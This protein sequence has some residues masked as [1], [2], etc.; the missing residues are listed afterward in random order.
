MSPNP[1]DKISVRSLCLHNLKSID[2][3]IPHG[4]F[5]VITGPSGAGK[6]SLALDSIYAE[7]QRRY[8]ETFSPYARQFLERLPRPPAKRI[9]GLPAAV[10]IGQSNPVKNSRST[11]GTLAEI[12]YPAHMLFYYLAELFCPECDIPVKKYDLKEAIDELK[13][14]RD[15]DGESRALIVASVS[16][17]RVEDFI[18]Q[19][20]FRHYQEGE[21]KELE[22]ETWGNKAASDE[23]IEIVID[24]ITLKSLDTERIRDSV[25]Q[26]FIAGGGKFSI[27]SWE[28]G[29]VVN[30]YNGLVCRGCGKTFSEPS[31][32]LFSFNSPSGACPACQGFGRQE[33][34][35]WDLVVPDH[36][37]S[38][39][40]GA[41]RP[42]ENWTGKKKRLLTWCVK[43][44]IP[45]ESPW[46]ELSQDVKDIIL[47]GGRGWPGIKSFFDR[48]EKK[49]YK[50]HIRILLA[51]YRKFVT[52]NQCKGKRFRKEVNQYR[53]NGLTLPDFYAL[54][55]EHALD[56]T[57]EIEKKT[58]KN[59][60]CQ[61]LA[62]DLLTRFETLCRAGLGYLSSERQAR[63]LS[64]GEVARISLARG[65]GSNLARTLYVLDEPTAGL[66]PAD[67]DRITSLIKG[68]GKRSNTVIAVEHNRQMAKEADIEIALGPGSGKNGG[69]V[70]YTGDPLFSPFNISDRSLKSIRPRIE[71]RFI[72]IKGASVHNL[73][74]ID[75]RLPLGAVSCITGV[76]GSGKSSLAD[77]IIYR[78]A[79]RIK[80]VAT[81]RPGTFRSIEN[82]QEIK[83]IILSDQTSLSRN[84]RACPG[85]FLKIMDVVRK[86]FANTQEAK[87]MGLV[88]GNFSFNTK[89][90]R[91]PLCAGQGYEKIDMQF[92]P[93]MTLP[94]PECRGSRFSNH[95]MGILYNGINIAQI[96]GMT[97]DEILQLPDMTPSA[98]KRL[99]LANRLGLGHLEL[100]R[101]LDTLSSGEAR[102]LKIAVHLLSGDLKDSLIVMDEPSKGLF[103]EEKEQLFSVLREASSKLNA[104][105]VMVEHDPDFVTTSDWVIDLGPG[106][107]D[108]GGQ[109]LYQGAPPGLMEC[110]TSLTGKFLAEK[111]TS[112]SHDTF[113]EKESKAEQTELKP[114]ADAIHIRGARHHNLKNIDIDIPHG[115]F[116]VITGVSGSGKS[117]IAFDIIFAEGQRR[118]IEG[119]SS[120]MKQYIKLYEQP[121]LDLAEGLTP[122][123]SIEQRTSRAGPMST[124]ATLTEIAHYLRLLYAKASTP[125][126]V[127]CGIAMSATTEKMIVEH[128]MKKR[129][130]EKLFFLAPV[131]KRRKGRH[132]TEIK[133][134]AA[135]GYE[136]I[137]VDGVISNFDEIK[138]LARF[139][140][141][142]IEFVMGPFEISADNRDEIKASIARALDHGNGSMGVVSEHEKRVEWLSRNFACPEC[143][144]SL[145]RSDPLMFSFHNS[146]GRCPSCD[147]RGIANENGTTCT[148]CQGSRLAS[149]VKAWRIDRVAIDLF[150]GQEISDALVLS[151]KWLEKSP[152]D[153]R[154]QELARPLMEKVVYRLKF[155]ENIGLGYLSLDRG[156]DTL[157]G[158]EA[159][160]IR[161]AVQAGSG[162]SGIT[163]VLDEP[164]IGLHHTDNQRLIKALKS[165]GEDGNTVVVVE[166]DLDTIRA[167]DMVIDLGPGGG[168]EGGEVV[169]CGPLAGLEGHVKSNTASA[170]TAP[171]SK[172]IVARK[173]LQDKN[174][175]SSV[176]RVKFK[177]VNI[178]HF[179]NV[180]FNLP[181]ESLVVLTGVSGAGKSSLLTK[182]I[183]PSL[184]AVLSQK[185]LPKSVEEIKGY[186]HIKRV[187]TV[188]HS[189]I[190][191]TPRSCPVTYAGIWSD[192]RE[193]F[194][195]TQAARIRGISPSFF[196][197]NVKGGRCEECAGQGSKRVTLGILPDIFV[198]CESCLGAR[199]QNT[200]LDI[201]WRSKN[202]SEILFMTI[203]EAKELFK[204]IPKIFRYL[205]VMENLGIGYIELGQPAPTL[206]GGEAQRLKLARE[207]SGRSSSGTVYLLDEPTTGLHAH[208]VKLLLKH[209]QKLVDTGNTVVVV[210]HNLDVIASADWL[211]DLGPG[212]GRH[213]GHIIFKGTP[214]ECAC[215]DTPTGRALME[216]TSNKSP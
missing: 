16:S 30:F 213:G 87:A 61:A 216:F 85:T 5:T 99:Q 162:L 157:S 53:L 64:G 84:P 77:H 210:E 138:P 212:G 142:S 22:A 46:E 40:E 104:T 28:K 71:H 73:K 202:I 186:D 109:V 133:K 19:G 75:V 55:F 195:S 113:L 209:L 198:K 69:K 70:V 39:K 150:F 193:L 132:E 199:Y 9:E 183:E 50:T 79:C 52:C 74:D 32:G 203:S 126:C 194:A 131:I 204:A 197:F 95:I 49:R 160:R 201:T 116:T 78:G 129:K 12:N 137:R 57:C 168:S 86:I 35:D 159:Q 4:S 145:E 83:N 88:P 11:A 68:L 174:S 200:I 41:I 60:A 7:A 2:L 34:I 176:S 101:S 185:P 123:V 31:P 190:G 148:T 187:V 103:Q 164:T 44:H 47:F 27:I 18:S 120:Y 215:L 23:K 110:S 115:K 112:S 192:I 167:A 175:L 14:L 153:K 67:I 170:L 205:S 20:F 65:I 13:R 33:A 139:S 94:C 82:I 151:G 54:S 89:A 125:W 188:D 179:H 45:H 119:L 26:A 25:N 100:G 97:L 172:R 136:L 37:I 93:D 3:D 169:F 141:H 15:R 111:F 90:G 181:T 165:L 128:I 48:M 140:E 177:G 135:L 121:D 152:W 166:H 51:R 161:L 158:G 63:T 91:C 117:S 206:S 42:L 38:I 146:A 107:G 196:S 76:S 106:G 182:V 58:S 6:S 62:A 178:N 191:R 208:D 96:M 66:H 147:G 102:R 173:R 143:G 114:Q 80:G 189:P 1:S 24:R 144:N 149:H 155:L 98:K 92:L 122:S 207:L 81:E 163:V 36:S 180:E 211:I 59:R 127:E 29:R 214:K 43:E 124:V 130:G 134:G 105:I 118:Y 184:S 17:L 56:W 8:I 154:N 171:F 10:A 72:E 156:G 21:V 108:R